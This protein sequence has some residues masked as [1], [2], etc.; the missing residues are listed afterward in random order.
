MQADSHRKRKA[1]AQL[2]LFGGVAFDPL[3]DC[4]VC[5][6]R[7]VGREVHRAHHKLCT[8]NRRTQGIVSEVTLKQ[9]KIDESLK[10][11][12]STP[13]APEE[14]ASSRYLT[15]EA[16]EAFFAIRNPPSNIAKTSTS[17]VLVSSTT[18]TT[19]A[20]DTSI[21]ET[22]CKEVTAK[23]HDKAF[24]DGH[25][26]GRAPLA[27]LAFASV[28]VE[29]IVRDKGQIFQHFKDLTLH[30]PPT[31]D[32]HNDPHYHSIVGQKLLLVD[33]IKLFGLD[34]QCPGC[35]G[36]KLV[37]D[38]TNFSKNK[39]LFPVFGIDGPP[40]WCMVMSMRCTCCC[41][42]YW[43]NDGRILNQL[44]AHAA[45]AYPVESK[46]ALQKHCHISKEATAVFDILMTTYG[47]GNLCSRLLHNATNR[48]HV[49]RVTS[50]CSYGQSFPGSVTRQH[51]EKDGECIRAYPPLGDAVRDTYDA[52]SSSVN[53]RW[54][55]SDHDRHVREIQA[56]KCE[57]LY[58]EDHTH[59]VTKNYFRRKQLGA[60]ALWDVATES[61]EIAT[62][63]LVPSTKTIHLSHAA[64]QLSRRPCFKPKAMCSDRW[65]TKTEYWSKVF[66]SDLEGRLGLFHFAQRIIRT[67]RK[68]HI[69]YFFA[70]NML[71]NAVCFYNQEDYENLLIVLKDGRLN[72]KKH[73]D[74]DVAEL[75]STKCFR[76]RYSRHLRKEIRSPN[77][78]QEKLDEWFVRFK[79]T[80]SDGSLP[81]GGRLDPISKEALFTSETKIAV[82]NCKETCRHLQDPLPL[83]EMYD[84]T[85]ANPNSPHGLKECLS[86]RGKSNLESF[87]LMLA[88]FGNTGMRESLADNLNLTGTARYNL[89]IRHK[90]SL[91]VT[92]TFMTDENTRRKIPA[93]WETVVSHF[94]HS[95]LTYIN[96]LA[97]AAGMKTIPFPTAEKLPADNGERFFSECLSWLK[98]VK[99]KNDLDD[100]CL[101]FTCTGAQPPP[102]TSEP[103]KTT[104]INPV[105]PSNVPAA[106]TQLTVTQPPQPPPRQ[107]LCVP[108]PLPMMWINPYMIPFNNWNH[109]CRKYKEHCCRLDKR[110]R[111]PHDNGCP[112]K[113]KPCSV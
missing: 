101:C 82:T 43:A 104:M 97:V 35:D 54:G 20:D 106:T 109:C 36:A 69:D 98:E 78:I 89:K 111:P 12:F 62:A 63:V 31:K 99:P 102:T 13:L 9:K 88:H 100:M 39:L 41:R 18:T 7:L 40:S 103:Q 58:A 53:T 11:H 68:R 22:F 72:G 52:A 85:P 93:A 60:L 33:W 25:A 110:G 3:T 37:N 46:C 94:N 77:V 107:H 105:G 90:R 15:K 23:L 34:T 2:T 112:F 66:G 49:E 73:S 59:E 21:A 6:G 84:T 74:E 32:M 65:P 92:G 71:L 19:T 51:I 95:E 14:R 64:I 50:Y 86:R 16:G 47:N 48:A 42:R 24:V 80:A 45:A 29:K 28:V 56:V 61:G 55:I 4:E 1:G 57:R 67:L 38:R 108:P 27:M 8:N 81:A 70:I 44:P 76:Q 5:K 10:K 75:K 113:V 87:H 83:N 17:K 26:N 96:T 30:V 91:T 79:C